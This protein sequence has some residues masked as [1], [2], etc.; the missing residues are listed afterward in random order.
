LA[1]ACYFCFVIVLRLTKPYPIIMKI[2]SIGSPS[3]YSGIGEVGLSAIP[4]STHPN[5]AELRVAGKV[6]GE[7][8]GSEYSAFVGTI[9]T[10][11]SVN[12]VPAVTVQ[13]QPFANIP[14]RNA[15]AGKL[16]E[17]V[18]T[19]V[20]G[21]QKGLLHPLPVAVAAPVVVTPATS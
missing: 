9:G 6:V 13:L 1:V 7:D 3:G 17:D 12:P 15:P 11:E 18:E 10:G 20:P 5:E 8:T 19:E 16:T 4:A 2:A 14:S 21:P